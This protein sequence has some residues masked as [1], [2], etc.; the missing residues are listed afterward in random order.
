MNLRNL[1]FFPLFLLFGF[2]LSAQVGTL[3]GSVSSPKGEPTPGIF[4]AQKD[5][6]G[7]G[8][9]T[10]ANGLFEIKL[11]SGKDVKVIFKGTGGKEE[12]KTFL[13]ND[14]EIRQVQVIYDDTNELSPIVIRGDK[15]RETGM[16]AIETKLPTPLPIVGG[17][18]EGYLIQTV[19]NFSSELSASYSVRGGSF[20]ENLVYV[21]GIQVY[22]PFLVRAGQQEG[23]SFPNPAM[24]RNIKFS[25]G[26]FE[27][28]YGDKMSSVLDIQYNRPD[29]MGGSIMMSLLGASVQFEDISKN[30]KFTHNTGI[31][32]KNNSYV[33]NSLDVKGD[34]RPRYVDLQTYL[35]FQPKEYGPWEFSFLGFYSQNRYNFTPSTRQ[36]D[37][38]NINEA[39]RLSVY[40]DGQELTKYDTYFAS[41]QS[42]YN[43]SESSQ[44][45]FT[46]SSFN[47]R[48]TEQFDVQGAYRL[49]ELERD[50][51]SDDFGQV[52]KNRGIGGFLNHGRNELNAKVYNVN[53]KGFKEFDRSKHLVNWG[54]EYQIEQVKDKLRE[55]SL[56]DSA[57]YASTRPA[58]PIVPVECDT[59]QW[60][61]PD[62]IIFLHDKVK[63]Y[64][65]VNS[66]RMTTYLQDE[67]RWTK[68]SGSVIAMNVGLR[69]NYWS[70]NQQLVS[71]PRA[72]LSYTPQ[73]IVARKN[74]QGGIDSIKKDIVLRAS[75]GYY[76]QP[77]FYR[78]M[79]GFDGRI[80]S[81]IRAQRSLHF[82]L[83]AD[84]LLQMWKRQFKLVVET[85][86][87]KL[88]FLIPY[89]V[90]NVRQ[91]YFARNNSKGYAY[92]L[93][94]MINGEFIQG[95]QSW[96]RASYLKT[97]EDLRDDYYY[98]YL[99][100]DGDTIVNGYTQNNVVVDSIY[101]S[102]GYIPRPSDQRFSFSLLFMDEMPQKP[103][104]KVIL[105]LYFATGVPYGPPSQQRYLD[106][107][108]TR[109]YIRA[110]I[111]FSR[112][113]IL[114]KN[115]NKNWF[116][117]KFDRGSISLEVF[118]LL[119]T[120]NII[121]HQWVEDAY[122]RQYGIP[123]YLTGRRL[124]LRFSLDF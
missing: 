11:P 91:R 116:N 31:R 65:E 77:A 89:K 100:S 19:A 43:P 50:L 64:N 75:T 3:R 14:G 82:I 58:D 121:N 17:G 122:G 40:F 95:V 48:E 24:V 38:G 22:R 117:R 32:Y 108:R 47:T 42:R 96:V 30:R 61:R 12:E 79:R 118:N 73:W 57:G 36:T 80:N 6:P 71:G 103:W 84:Y 106:V 114:K 78:E 56:I 70:F 110:D 51:G 62:Q 28:K 45:N 115:K 74:E 76:W 33:F 7:N 59:C 16:K 41:F 92:G 53:L 26:G 86:Y 2:H 99:N 49:D 25:A 55:W 8:C 97:E 107:F 9:V 4:I 63:A 52:L 60:Q 69:A 39:L 35:T 119:G 109:S 21:N 111:G 68:K 5:V 29:S 27:S 10:D 102:P 112:D 54:I 93:D 15:G 88:D 18:I 85:Y 1:L 37:V 98:I 67:K 113:L 13:L 101:N 66:S 124:N 44:V 105:N 90:E 83:G 120:N 87:K 34:Y 72:I 104:Y 23:L 81:E 94:V 20:D 46:L 123:T